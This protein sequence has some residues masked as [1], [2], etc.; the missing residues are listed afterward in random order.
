MKNF[1]AAIIV[2]LAFVAAATCAVPVVQTPYGS[3]SGTHDQGV[4]AFRGIP[5]AKP[6][7]GNLR[8]K[9][10]EEVEPW[11]GVINGSQFQNGCLS[12]CPTYAFPV[13]AIMC[14]PKMS[15]DC[16]FLNVF[17]PRL[18]GNSSSL[19][20]V[21]VFMHGG[22]YI[23]GSGGVPLYDG[24]DMARNQNVVVVT[25]NYRLGAFGALF[26]GTVKGNLHVTD[27]RQALIFVSKAISAFGGNPNLV[28]LTGQSA[29]A[30]SVATHLA[31][32]WSWPYFHRAIIISNPFTLLAAEPDEML[33]LSL[34][35][36]KSLNCTEGG[37]LELNCLQNKTGEEILNAWTPAIYD[38][39]NDGFL[40]LFLE[41]VPTVDGNQLP[42]Q[43]LYALTHEQFNP[44]P[45]MFGTVA[46]ESVE[47]IYGALFFPLPNLFGWDL[48][49]NI[50][51]DALFVD[52]A[53]EVRKFYGDPPSKNEWDIRP[54]L[55]VIITD[56]VF[57]CPNRFVGAHLTKSTPTFMWYFDKNPS[58]S[59]PIYGKN[60]PYCVNNVCHAD[61]LPFIF[62]PF[63]APLPNGY[64]PPEP[65][66]AEVQLSHQMQTAWGNFARTGDPNPLPNGLHFPRFDGAVNNL[67]NWSV[68]ATNLNGYR[69]NVCD[70]FDQKVGY[71]QV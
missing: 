31:S 2:V 18:G 55:T 33:R 23:G 71:Y 3:V 27:Q 16:L 9:Y 44:V 63:K 5:F 64:I 42:Y 50:V 7:V 61:D 14:T 28:T 32:P 1:F 21:V 47:F 56:Y 66:T 60:M 19:L 37:D 17:T 36:L 35:V 46:N 45:I 57:Y 49:Y 40:S 41:W 11:S 65:T 15:E 39:F 26:T 68:P 29:G 58:Y 51:L 30:F 24:A 4:Y 12:L 38:P 53:D 25:T 67:M 34:K 22:D 43:P 6:P 10:A 54:F 70:F 48:A 52:A 8:F 20:P 62:N 13:P 59:E 69:N